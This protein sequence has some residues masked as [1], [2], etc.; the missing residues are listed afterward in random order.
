M[1]ITRSRATKDDIFEPRPPFILETKKKT[2]C[3]ETDIDNVKT[4]GAR[5]HL[6]PFQLLDYITMPNIDT[7]DKTCQLFENI[8]VGFIL[9]ISG[10][11]TYV[12]GFYAVMDVFHPYPYYLC[13]IGFLY[14]I[15]WAFVITELVNYL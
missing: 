11:L 6:F 12:V 10:F 5:T 4:T 13:G 15:V 7:F 2:I 8:L 1:P 3:Q 14:S 9:L